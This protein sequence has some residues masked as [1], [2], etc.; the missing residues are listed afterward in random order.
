MRNF[1]LIASAT[2]AFVSVGCGDPEQSGSGN[3]GGAS[4]GGATTGSPDTTTGA[5]AGGAGGAG[6]ATTGEAGD[7]NAAGATTGDFGAAGA[8]G[9]PSDP[10]WIPPVVTWPDPESNEPFLL[11]ETGLYR[12][13]ETEELAPDLIAFE[14]AHAL[15]SD[16]ATKRRWVR[17]PQGSVIDTSDMNH[18]QVPV[19]TVFFKEFTRDGVRVETRAIARIGPD[20]FDY[21]MGAFVWNQA[22]TD[23]EFRPDGEE[24]ARGTEHDVPTS[25]QCG[26]CH[27]GEPGRALGFSALQLSEGGRLAELA[28]A[29][30]LSDPPSDDERFAA[31]GDPSTAAALGYLHANCGHCH[32]PDGS[33][34]PDTNMNLRLDLGQTSP[35]TTNAYLTTVGVELQYFN[36]TE[37]SYR[38]E[39]G[40]PE[41]SALIQRMSERG[42]DTQMPPFATELV[43]DDGVDLVSEWIRS[44][45]E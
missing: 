19:G 9:G 27:N 31:P 18:W 32:N 23:A 8:A 37:L 11:S 28:Q 12:D 29:G 22:G 7:S 36:D 6:G 40:D 1:I 16:G 26:T 35:E 17:F 30:L 21:W 43:H 45:D 13:I 2:L 15:W 25:T 14:P 34:R 38:V 20:R 5:G 44:L 42:T 39:A 33:A 24:N 41:R 3:A 4:A 10:E